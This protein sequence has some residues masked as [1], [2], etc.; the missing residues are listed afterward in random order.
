[1]E[2]KYNTFVAVLV[3]TEFRKRTPDFTAWLK[4]AIERSDSRV[5]FC[6]ETCFM[7]EHQASIPVDVPCKEVRLF[8]AVHLPG[9][10]DYMV[11]FL[12]PDISTLELF[13]RKCLRGISDVSEIIRD[14]YT[15]V[16]VP[17]GKM[18]LPIYQKKVGEITYQRLPSGLEEKRTKNLSLPVYGN[19]PRG[20]E[21]SEK[22]KRT[23]ELKLG[24]KI[25]L[26]REEDT[27]ICG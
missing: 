4:R 11:E 17:I 8:N 7:K 18:E 23:L 16:G 3:M 21:N 12:C 1:L 22:E 19:Y 25:F 24:S 6:T 15:Y 2:D 9:A 20:V 10:Y 14:T 27:R 13:V 5:E 26:A